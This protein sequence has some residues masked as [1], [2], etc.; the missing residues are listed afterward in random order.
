MKVL[1]ISDELYARLRNCVVDPFDD[2]PESVVG[3]L[4]DIVDKAKSRL[5]PWDPQKEDLLQHEDSQQHEQSQQ[6]EDTQEAEH[7]PLDHW[8]KQVEQAL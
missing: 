4:I 5:S 8:K 6:Q 3:R 2:T 1:E 7:M